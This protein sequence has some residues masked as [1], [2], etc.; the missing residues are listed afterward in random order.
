VSGGDL[1]THVFPREELSENK[2][3]FYISEIIFALEHIHKLG[4][5]HRDVK[6]ENI[7][8]N[9]QGHVVL[10][11]FSLSKNFFPHE[12][13][14][15]YSCCGTF[16]YMVPQVIRAGAGHQMAADYWSVGVATYELLTRISPFSLDRASD[17]EEKISPTIYPL[18][19]Q[20]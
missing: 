10:T 8:R 20:I 19:H 18:L 17:T 3:R 15:M 9:L 2:I 5:I 6:M 1:F 12:T 4:I 11:D 16:K 14:Q 13:H 7:L